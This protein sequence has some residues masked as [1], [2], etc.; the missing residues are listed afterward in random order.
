MINR[1]LKCKKCGKVLLRTY[2]GSVATVICTCGN[3]IKL[4]LTKDDDYVYLNPD[5]EERKE[6]KND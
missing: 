1:Q 5:K 2:S 3:I 4:K 6:N